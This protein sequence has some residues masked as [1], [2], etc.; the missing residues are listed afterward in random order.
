MAKYDELLV[1]KARYDLLFEIFRYTKNFTEE[2]KYTIGESLKKE[3]VELITL[4]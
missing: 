2:Y 4:I 1:Y 3:T